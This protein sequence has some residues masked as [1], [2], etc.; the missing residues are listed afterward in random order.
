MEKK[1]FISNE[2]V[3]ARSI[4]RIIGPI[5]LLTG[6][7]CIVIAT[8]EFFTLDFFEEPQLFWLA[9]VGMPIVFV[10]F[11]LSG[12]GYGSIV[13]KYQSREMAPVARDTFNYLAGETTE[14]VEKI[15]RAVKTGNSSVVTVKACGSCNHINQLDAKYCNE[16][17]NLL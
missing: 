11:I 5:V 4:F 3:K 13:A 17:G 15:A 7:V 8:V 9:F 14:G 10:G 2:H 1:Q 12:L 6:I 16:C